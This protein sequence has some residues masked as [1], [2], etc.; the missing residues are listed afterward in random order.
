MRRS[1][2]LACAFD[3]KPL[4][5]KWLRPATRLLARAGVRIETS[6]RSER[7]GAGISDRA[8]LEFL[9]NLADELCTPLNGII[10]SSKLIK[11]QSLG[12]VGHPKYVEYVD[13]IHRCAG[14]LLSIASD[15]RDISKIDAGKLDPCDETVAAGDAV[16]EAV[17][18]I[19][20]FAR[21]AG[22]RITMHV[23]DDLPHLLVGRSALMKILLNLLSNAV[24]F[25]RRNG[26]VTVSART[27]RSGACTIAVTDTGTGIAGKNLETAMSRFGKVANPLTKRHKGLGLGLPLTKALIEQHGGSLTLH[28]TV[29]VGT[30]ATVRF[31]AAR[32]RAGPVAASSAARQSALQTKIF[33]ENRDALIHVFQNSF[34]NSPLSRYLFRDP[35]SL[36]DVVDPDHAGRLAPV[37]GGRHGSRTH[38]RFRGEF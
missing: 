30:I 38:S 16:T 18:E 19:R 10:E 27:E 31:P 29:G 7:E 32:V 26:H 5:Q 17:R 11:D 35:F 8:E 6:P 15:I 2:K 4:F 33:I 28:S 22:I 24:K 34:K 20:P 25:N 9:A 3:S 37:F 13:E 23:A 36:R 12:P 14:H 21:D 1:R